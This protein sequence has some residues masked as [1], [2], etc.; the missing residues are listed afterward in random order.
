[1]VSLPNLNIRTSGETGNLTWQTYM[2]MTSSLGPLSFFQHKI[3][4]GFNLSWVIVESADP[5]SIQGPAVSEIA[6][7]SLEIV[8][9]DLEQ[10]HEDLHEYA[11]PLCQ[12]D[13]DIPLLPFHA[14]NHTI[15]LIDPHKIYPWHPSHCPKPLRPL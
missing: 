6:S 9:D 5:V 13:E 11:Q 10:I 8:E 14:I 7:C 15:P 12:E 3:T 4:F 1:M 2:A